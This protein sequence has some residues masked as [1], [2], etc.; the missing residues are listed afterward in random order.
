MLLDTEPGRR[1]VTDSHRPHAAQDGATEDDYT[2]VPPNVVFGSDETE[3]TFTFI[4]V[5]DTEDDDE[6][7]RPAHLRHPARRPSRRATKAHGGRS[8]SPTT[9]TPD[10]TVRFEQ[11]AYSVEEDDD[12]S[13]T[14]VQENRVEVK[15]VLSA[16]PERTVTIP[17]TDAGKDGATS[18]DYTLAP[19]SVTFNPGE[20]EQTVIFTAT[21]DSDNDDGE[22]VLL[23]FGSPLPDRVTE[24]D[25][26]NQAAVYITDGDFPDVTVRFEGDTAHTL[27][28]GHS[29]AIKVILS[30]DP[31]RPVTIPIDPSHRA[32]ATAADYTL[33]PA[34]VTF[35]AGETEKT[36][37]FNAVID[38]EYEDGEKVR[39]KFGAL[40]LRMSEGDPDAVTVEILDARFAPIKPTGHDRFCPVHWPLGMWTNGDDLYITH[41]VPTSNGINLVRGFS[42]QT[43]EMVRQVHAGRSSVMLTGLWSDDGTTMWAG[44]YG[45][46]RLLAYG[47]RDRSKDKTLAP[48]NTNAVGMTVAGGI[49]WVGDMDDE[50]VYAYDW[51]TMEHLSD[52]DFPLTA[53]R[54][55]DPGYAAGNV[56]GLWSNGVTLWVTDFEDKRIYAY[57]VADGSRKR[58]L[59]LRLYPE[60]RE[61]GAIT[62]DGETMFVTDWDDCLVYRYNLPGT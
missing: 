7:L 40:P 51:A 48:E 16:D 52:R 5:H 30:A 50:K 35:A 31:E 3:Q 14:N 6:R 11:S 2:V 24:A 62:S 8:P 42:I 4:A 21:D 43:G 32:G 29:L 59:D 22:S 41:N 12:T 61:P 53:G 1:S 23:S 9:T 47:P 33:D 19:T 46:N 60:N 15:V 18:A 37:T 45:E 26:N 56:Q 28:E 57:S 55:A 54:N 44:V 20:T 13:T 10:V 34:S 17:I 38:S 58:A 49:L 36:F 39:L 27:A 25:T